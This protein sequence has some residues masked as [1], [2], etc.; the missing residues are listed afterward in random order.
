LISIVNGE[1]GQLFLHLKPPKERRRNVEEIIDE[2]RTRL[3]Q[4]PGFR[5]YLRKPG[6]APLRYILTS[7]DFG[8]LAQWTPKV[9][10]K[11]RAL[12]EVR[13]IRDDLHPGSSSTINV[14]RAKAR[15]SGIPEARIETA[16]SIFDGV[17]VSNEL[18]VI[19][20]LQP[21]WLNRPEALSKLYISGEGDKLVPLA[22][23]A[24]LD[25]VSGLAVVNH[26]GQFPSV[27]ISFDLRPGANIDK[28]LKEIRLPPTVNGSL[29]R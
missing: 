18:P 5:L 23:L 27:T 1:G 12:P 20:E 9:E 11:L 4:F 8:A 28:A 21:G 13:D 6:T 10:E 26:T 16:L 15:A 19:L 3:T 14:D 24:T 25:R 29:A 7:T 2:L 17:K 22:T